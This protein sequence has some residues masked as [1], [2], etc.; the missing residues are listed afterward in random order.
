MFVALGLALLL[1]VL[2]QAVLGAVLAILELNSGVKPEELGGVI[3]DRLTSPYV[4]ILMIA[5]GQLAFGLAG[6]LPA[7]WSPLPFRER[8]G[9]RKAQLSWQLYPISMLG[10]ILLKAV[11]W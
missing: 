5:A 11:C 4:F 8:V 3:L 6:F 2:F 7:F 1:S 10:E 9:W